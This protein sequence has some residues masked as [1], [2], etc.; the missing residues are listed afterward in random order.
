MKKEKKELPE[1]GPE[2]RAEL[3]RRLEALARDGRL[4]CRAA[5]GLAT[6]LGVAPK[7][8]GLMADELGI[9]IAHCQLQC[10]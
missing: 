3:T 7:A 5:L 4:E 1:I 8:V 10:F 6:T 9:R 2:M